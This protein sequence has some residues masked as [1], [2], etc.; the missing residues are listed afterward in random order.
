LTDLVVDRQS[1]LAIANQGG[2]IRSQIENEGFHVPKNSGLNWEPACSQKWDRAK[3]YYYLLQI[4]HRLMQLLRLT[5]GLG[6][7]RKPMATGV[8]WRFGGRSKKFLSASGRRFVIFALPM[9]IMI[10]TRPAAVRWA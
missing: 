1:V 9:K 3:V 7:W 2:R 8:S 10:W 5:A 4:G 6:P